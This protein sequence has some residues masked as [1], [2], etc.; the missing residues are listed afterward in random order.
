MNKF[1][2]YLT[3][4]VFLSSVL[5]V[6]AQSDEKAIRRGNRNYKSGDYEQAI[7]NYRK[8]LEIRPNNAKAQFNLGDAY[9][10]KQSYDTAFIEF[11]KVLEMSPDAKLKSDAVF[12]MGNCLLAQNKYYDAFMMASWPA[13]EAK[14]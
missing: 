4:I 9:Y 12:N 6:S 14:L 2:K 5:T 8:A 13:K 11:Q 1:I 7:T 3:I 10:A